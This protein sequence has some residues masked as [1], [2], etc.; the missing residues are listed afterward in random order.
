M[1]L[2]FIKELKTGEISLPPCGTLGI[3]YGTS[4]CWNMLGKIIYG[5]SSI[6]Q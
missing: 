1:D 4:P 3:S 2:W 6:A 5:R